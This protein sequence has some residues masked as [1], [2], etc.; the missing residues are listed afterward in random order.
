MRQF[1]IEQQP[2]VLLITPL[3][4]IG[5]PQLD[6]FAAARA[7]GVRTVL[8]VGSWDHLSS[9]ALLRSVPD[10]VVVWNQVQRQEA[11]ELHGV[12][13][14]RVVVTGAQCYDQWFDRLPARSREDFC[15]RVGLDPGR[16]FVLYTCSSLFRGTVDE[17]E[18][19]L[20]WVRAL[21]TSADP[22]LKGIGILIRPHPARLDE[23]RGVDL[24]GS[25]N[26]VFWGAHPVD[27]EA[28]GRLLRLDVLQ[29]RR[30]RHQHQRVHRGRGSGQAGPHRA[31]ARGVARQPGRHA[32]LPL[33]ARRSTAGC[34]AAARSFEE[35]LTLLAES[36]APAGG[37]D[38][39]AAPLR[40]RIR[41]AVRTRRG[42]DAAIR[43][44]HRAGGR[45]AGPGP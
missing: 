38:E 41:P 8:P 42:S 22:R 16:P 4:D 19:V 37:G 13:A 17:P 21:R 25:K 26:L 12:P 24:S 18:F 31:A 44:G 20:A 40:G 1:L 36:L 11:L 30:R 43:R 9:K 45:A 10:R 34:C 2:D 39:K 23:W 27:A 14:D 6:H 5:S 35:H 28:E 7:V 29:R 33:S 15:A 32:A 3:I